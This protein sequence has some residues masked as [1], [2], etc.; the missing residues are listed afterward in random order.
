MNIVTLIAVLISF[1]SAATITAKPS[2]RRLTPEM[3]AKRIHNLNRLKQKTKMKLTINQILSRKAL[4]WLIQNPL[5]ILVNNQWLPLK[6][7]F[8][9]K[10]CFINKRS[11]IWLVRLRHVI[12][13]SLIGFFQVT[14][15]VDPW[16]V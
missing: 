4:I 11:I 1:I 3:V 12:R 8:L 9:F 10:F 2:Y 5:V 6:I 16:A 13:G 15:T 7:F 14:S